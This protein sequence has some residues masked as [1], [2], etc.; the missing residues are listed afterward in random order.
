M[1]ILGESRMGNY[2]NH[3]LWLMTGNNPK[4]SMEIARRAIRIRIDPK[5]DRPWLRTEF[6]H[7][8]LVKWTLENRSKLIHAVLVLVQNW[9]A[10]D[11]PQGTATLGSFESWAEVTG[12]ILN[13]AGIDGFLGS[14]AELYENADAEGQA[15]REFIAA[16]WET[17]RSDPKSV[18]DLND[19]CDDHDLMIQVR[20][21]KSPRS[22]QTRL[23][24]ALSSARDRIFGN[25]KISRTKAFSHKIGILYK[26]EITDEN[27]GNV[28]KGSPNVPPNVPPSQPQETQQVMESG[29]TL[30]TFAPCLRV[31]T[32][33][34]DTNVPNTRVYIK[35]EPKGY[36]TFPP[37]PNS[38]ENKELSGGTFDSNVP[39]NVP[40]R[41]PS[42]ME[43]DVRDQFRLPEPDELPE[44]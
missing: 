33:L 28:S 32:V 19:F 34:R 7:P 23:G 38:N 44:D 16:W 10:V 41:S 5:Q 9:I 43:A 17:F 25:I 26:L 11:R 37:S 8:K 13:A 27:G 14:L 4:L 39:S 22:E 6:K 2:L 36:P 30:R 21:E 40:Q 42:D 31:E 3:A 12:G 1:R 20:G 35:E 29:G 24:L 18:K 15:W